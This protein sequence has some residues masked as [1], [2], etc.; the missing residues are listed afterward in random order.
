LLRQRE[1]ASAAMQAEQASLAKR[2]AGVE[3]ELEHIDAELAAQAKRVAIAAKRGGAR[4]ADSRESA[5]CHPAALDRERDN[6]TRPL[7]RARCSLRRARLAL[8]RELSSLELESDAARSRAGAQ[9]ARPRP[10]ARVHRPGAHRARPAIPRAIVA[11][12]GGIVATVLVERGQMVTPGMPLATII[13]VNATLE[14]HLYSP[15]RSIGFVHAGPGSAAA[16]P[17]LS[18]PEV[19]HVPG[20]GDLGVAESPWRPSSSASRPADGSREPV[21]RIRVALDGQADRAYG[22]LEPLQPGMQV[23]ADILLDRRRLIEWIFEPL[24]SLAGRT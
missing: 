9:L 4:A 7:S 22:R 14:G 17:R 2:R 10:A 8:R 16:L 20:D 3:R 5:S 15:S 11:A 1:F 6:R 21:Y 23:E 18:A 13:P 19:R 12:G 24:L